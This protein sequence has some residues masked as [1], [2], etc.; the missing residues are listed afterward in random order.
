MSEKV[1]LKLQAVRIAEYRY[2]HEAE[3]A[4]GFLEHAG[5]PYRL[6][7]DDAG[8]A[9]LGLSLLRPSAI[10][11]RST[12]ARLAREL[13]DLEADEEDETPAAAVAAPPAAMIHGRPERAGATRLLP[14]ERGVS[15]VLSVA[16][17]SALPYLP[18]GPYRTYAG[19]LVLAASIVFLMIAG[20][21][22]GPRPV[23]GLLRMLAGSAPE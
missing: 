1:D 6:Q 4:A 7:I 18:F 14:L 8:G 9:D 16:L 17:F 12:D 15:V 3:F 19:A 2:R 22:R 20:F 10:W 21:G 11:V 5:I 23:E 13:L